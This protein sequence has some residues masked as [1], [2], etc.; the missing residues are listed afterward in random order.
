M[1]K[2]RKIVIYVTALILLLVG[3]VGCAEP[4]QSS[5]GLQICSMT[6]TMGAVDP[7]QSDEQRLSFTVNLCNDSDEDIYISFIEPLLSADINGR[8][9]SGD[10]RVEVK[11]KVTAGDSIGIDGEFIFDSSDLSKQDI[12][13]MEPIITGYRVGTEEQIEL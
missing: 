8:I 12:I 1:R 6:S 10:T 3:T 9:I 7:D 13:A 11:K 4:Q 5:Q 2:D